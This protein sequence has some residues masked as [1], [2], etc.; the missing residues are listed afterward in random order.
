MNKD[1]NLDFIKGLVRG[2]GHVAPSI[3]ILKSELRSDSGFEVPVLPPA[4]DYLMIRWTYHIKTRDLDDFHA[5]LKA[6][7]HLIIGDTTNV[8]DVQHMG[9]F[10]ELPGGNLHHTIWLYRSLAAVDVYLTELGKPAMAP[11][12]ANLREFVEFIKDP[13][14]TMTRLV[15]AKAL[16]GLVALQSQTDPILKMFAEQ[17]QNAT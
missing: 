9:T 1:N 16:D 2:A 12:K 15:R 8:P 17:S 11:L 13:A 14:M 4:D 10:A 5:F 7:E 3:E 6:K